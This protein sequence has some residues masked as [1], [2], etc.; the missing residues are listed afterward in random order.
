MNARLLYWGR[1]SRMTSTV[2]LLECACTDGALSRVLA[3]SNDVENDDDSPRRLITAPARRSC[4]QLTSLTFAA[5]AINPES[6]PVHVLFWGPV[7]ND[8]P[9][10]P[11]FGVSVSKYKS[12]MTRQNSP[13]SPN[14][15]SFSVKRRRWWHQQQVLLCWKMAPCRAVVAGCSCATAQIPGV[16][17]EVRVAHRRLLELNAEQNLCVQLQD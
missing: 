6:H 15:A 2:V 7:K 3:T 10:A 12:T 14:F 5:A 9:V 11:R 16:A 8:V 1:P 17:A 4:P 13:V